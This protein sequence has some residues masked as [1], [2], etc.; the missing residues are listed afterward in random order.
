MNVKSK[1]KLA[2]TSAQTL[3]LTVLP[4]TVYLLF[5]LFPFY[6]MVVTSV[7]T[8]QEIYATPLVYW[9]GEF[10]SA[11]YQKLFGYFDFLHYMK[12]SLLIALGTMLV[13]LFVSTLAAY[14]FSRYRFRGRKF[15]MAVF[16]SNNMFPTVLIMIPL[17]SILRSIGLLY[18]PG[19]M[20]LAYTTFT[21]PFSVWMIQ[22]FIRDMPFSLEESALVD[23]CNRVSAFVRIFLPILT[24][25][26]LATGVYIFMQSW[27]E[28]MM[29]SMF[30]NPAS[31]TIPVAL[32]SLIGQL[33][34][35]WDMLCAGGTIA[36]IPVCILF[37]FAQKQLVT[38]L[39]AGAVKG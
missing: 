15:L 23:G 20:I 18:R 26:L 24:P 37:F 11:A 7:K 17:Y 33:G 3:F 25:C 39:T 21:I 38:G 16:L 10:S 12:N 32:N 19:G 35:E 36:I 31:R 1:R 9:P 13:S 22:G 34:V 5:L 30:T 29:A 4:V 27:N 6:W 8:P 28:Y 2:S 14:A